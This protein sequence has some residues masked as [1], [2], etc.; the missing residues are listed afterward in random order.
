M[1]SRRELARRPRLVF[2][3][4]RRGWFLDSGGFSEL[5]QFGAWTITPRAYVA[6][7]CRYA[8]EIGRLELVAPQ[9][10][11]CEPWL[12]KKT[13][14]SVRAH[15]RRT[16]DNF[17]Q[18]RDLAPDLPWVPVVQ[19]WTLDDYRR[20]V[21]AYAR[22]GVDL[23]GMRRVGV[24]SVCRR[25]S[26]RDALEIFRGL[27]ALGLSLHGFGVKTAGFRSYRSLLA[28]ADSM[29]WSFGARRRNVRL[30]DCAHVGRCNHCL[31][32]AQHWRAQV[33]AK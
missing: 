19:G 15:I 17:V 30:A 29:A 7:V 20:C 18:L 26:T 11:M 21:D 33:L 14:L 4:A 24:G 27:R 12:V 28:S 5:T 23:A 1:L 3:R 16:V 10:W 8:R 32:Y 22:A 25:Q 31:A 6:E 13:G 2:P 9:D